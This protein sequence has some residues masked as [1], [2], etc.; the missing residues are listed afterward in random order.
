MA[1]NRHDFGRN[2][3][4]FVRGFA[5]APKSPNNGARRARA[6]ASWSG[7]DPFLS[8]IKRVGSAMTVCA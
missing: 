2:A 7:F 4:V 1:K 8:A 3:Q 5:T 6:R